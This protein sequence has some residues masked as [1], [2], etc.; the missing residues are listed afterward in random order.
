[1]DGKKGVLAGEV[2]I[3]IA[4]FQDTPKGMNPSVVL[5]GLNQTINR[6][7]NG[8]AQVLAAC[9]SAAASD[10]NAVVLNQS[11]DGVLCEMKWNYTQIMKYLG[12]ETN[13]LSFPD[14]NHN[15]KNLRYQLIGGSSA[16][17]IGRYTFDPWLLKEEKDVPKALVRV[18]YYASD[19]VAI[20]LGSAR[21]VNA[22]AALNSQ[23]AGNSLVS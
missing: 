6:S 2:K 5:A 10:H 16:A 15:V 21:A 23:D 18:D 19:A 22:I 3:A 12:G 4:N 8:G 20:G 14:T 11:T 17:S 7:N 13:V 1:M 9:V